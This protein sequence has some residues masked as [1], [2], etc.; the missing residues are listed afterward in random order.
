MLERPKLEFIADHLA[1]HARFDETAFQWDHLDQ[2][3]PQFKRHVRPLL[4]AIDFATTSAHAPLI[5]AVHFLRTAFRKAGRLVTIPLT[6]SRSASSRRP[7]NAICIRPIRAARDASSRTAMSFWSIACC[8]T[9]S[10]RAISSAQTVSASGVSKMTSWMI[11]N[12]RPRMCS[13]PTRVWRSS[14]NRSRSI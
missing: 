8:A 12:G 4:L 1:T 5:T 7:S 11:G 14:C 13:W 10:K 6:Y 3:A 9:A 2:L